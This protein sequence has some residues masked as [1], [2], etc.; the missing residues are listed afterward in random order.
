MK[1]SKAV[2]V[3]DFDNFHSTA[4]CGGGADMGTSCGAGGC[5]GVVHG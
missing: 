2:G 5:E 1:V 4:V 3:L